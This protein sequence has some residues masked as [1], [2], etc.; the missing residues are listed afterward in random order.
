MIF[1]RASN[2]T[3]P[4]L[5]PKNNFASRGGA[6]GFM[7]ARRL[8][9][10]PGSGARDQLKWDIYGIFMHMPIMS[11]LDLKKKQACYVSIYIYTVYTL[12]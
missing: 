1:P 10:S 4:D 12:P 2:P 7:W 6:A 9:G 3:D 8:Q 5:R 11:W